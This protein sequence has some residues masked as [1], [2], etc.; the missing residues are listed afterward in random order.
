[1]AAAGEVDRQTEEEEVDRQTEEE[2]VVVSEVE[3]Y[4]WEALVEGEG[5]LALYLQ[6]VL[7]KSWEEREGEGE[8]EEEEE[9][10]K[11]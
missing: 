2:V 7:M 4:A 8:G 3:Y 11:L 9:L 5:E 10:R 1:M 6:Q